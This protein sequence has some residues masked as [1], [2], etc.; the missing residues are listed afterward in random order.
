M[1]SSDLVVMTAAKA[2]PGKERKVLRALRDVAEAARAASGCVD[3]RIFRSAED[4]AASINFERWSSEEARATFLTGPAV[5]TFVT[6]VSGAFAEPPQPV[7]YQE[8]D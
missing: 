1:S 2:K 5:K 8:I 7:S 4:P 6:V 3:C